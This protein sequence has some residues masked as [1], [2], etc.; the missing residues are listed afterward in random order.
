MSEVYNCNICRQY[1]CVCRD[2][3]IPNSTGRY[4]TEYDLLTTAGMAQ[5]MNE[6]SKR[7]EKLEQREAKE[8]GEE[9]RSGNDRRK[10]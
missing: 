3:G 7:I 10:T 5:S 6:L 4:I 8:M 1:P 9:R 2:R